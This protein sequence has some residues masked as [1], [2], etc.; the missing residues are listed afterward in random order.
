MEVLPLELVQ[1]I[2]SAPGLLRRDVA[3]AAQTGE[4]LTDAAR[5]LLMRGL[6]A[7]A[8]AMGVGPTTD[9]LGWMILFNNCIV[10]DDAEGLKALLVESGMSPD[11]VLP[12][13]DVLCIYAE[14]TTL[15]YLCIGDLAV[16]PTDDVNQRAYGMMGL[17]DTNPLSPTCDVAFL[18]RPHYATF[19]PMANTMVVRAIDCGAV[20][21]LRVLL[22]AGASAKPSPE[23]L[24]VRALSHMWVGVRVLPVRDRSPY[25]YDSATDDMRTNLPKRAPDHAGIVAAL[26]GAFVGSRTLAPPDTNPLSALRL[27]TGTSFLFGYPSDHAARTDVEVSALVKQEHHQF[28]L[29]QRV[30]QILLAAGYSPDGPISGG[31]PCYGDTFVGFNDSMME[32]DSRTFAER[33]VLWRRHIQTTTERQGAIRCLALIPAPVLDASLDD[34]CAYH[35]QL[36]LVAQYHDLL[37]RLPRCDGGDSAAT[38]SHLDP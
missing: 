9:F 10:E 5:D 25:V 19:R 37:S 31:V 28:D 30:L 7:R 23:A 33:L 22:A 17:V 3:A 13:P 27:L 6:N 34:H 11:S 14:S 18:N 20:R 21:A 16:I 26:T 12:M 24:L 2:L 4:P 36:L 29:V 15:A 1:R 32:D 35:M 38:A 8:G